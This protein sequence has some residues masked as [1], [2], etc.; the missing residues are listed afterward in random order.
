MVQTAL[1]DAAWLGF[2]LE[3]YVFAGFGFWIFCFAMSRYSMRLERRLDT[4]H[5]R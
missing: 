2:A 4:G 1:T 5:R 3:G